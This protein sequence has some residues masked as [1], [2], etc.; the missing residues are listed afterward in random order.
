MTPEKI[1]AMAE[2]IYSWLY[3]RGLWNSVRIYFNGMAYGDNPPDPDSGIRWEELSS[4]K[5]LL[6]DV[7]PHNYF[8]YAGGFLSMSF[9]GAFYE[10]MNCW[11]RWETELYDAF[12]DLLETHYSCYFELGNSW[13][14]SVFP[15]CGW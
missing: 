14:L 6:H 4:G 9:E 11:T 10:V 5:Y 15:C 8:D 13:N 3:E 12:A 1:A 2:E 7:D